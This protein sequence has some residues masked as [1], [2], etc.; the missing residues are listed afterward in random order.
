MNNLSEPPNCMQF[1][2]SV[3]LRKGYYYTNWIT[4]DSAFFVCLT[5][6]NNNKFLFIL[7]TLEQICST[8]LCTYQSVKNV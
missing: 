4:T 7:F 2:T 6:T 8:D 5:T 1:V 3:Q